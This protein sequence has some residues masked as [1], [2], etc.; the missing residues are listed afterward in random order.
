[1]LL[2]KRELPVL[3]VNVIYLPVFATL[4]ASRGNYEFVLYGAVVLV[5]AIWV[6]MKQR[7]VRFDLFILWGL[8]LWG[9]LHMAGGNCYV[10]GKRLYALQLIRIALPPY[11]VLRYDH[12]VHLFG[13]G[14]VTLVCYHLLEPY[15]RE[16]TGRAWG[17]YALVVLMGTGV[18]AVNEILE[19]VAVLLV[20]ETGVGGYENTMLDLVFNLIGGVAAAAWIARRRRRDAQS[21]QS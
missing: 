16:R 13:F 11:E 17:L 6:L 1:M 14:V 7:T 4:A 15:L 18:G 8:T 20:P 5:L 12:V 2:T 19:F 10:A 21:K 3:A 9:L